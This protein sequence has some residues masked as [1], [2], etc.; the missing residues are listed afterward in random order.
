MRLSKILDV[1]FGFLVV[2]IGLAVL[3]LFA[4][5]YVLYEGNVTS[6]YIIL[7]VALNLILG[8]TG[9]LAFTNGVLFGVGAYAAAALTSRAGIPYLLALPS[10]AVVAMVVG[11]VIALPALRLSGLYLAMASVAFAQTAEWVFLH[12]DWATGGPSGVRMAMIRYPIIGQSETAHYYVS[13][14]VACIVVVL[15]RNLLRSRIGR[16][17][18]AIRESEVGA[19]SLA[20]DITRYKTLAYAASALL[21][22]LAG[23]LFAPLLGLV[24]PESYDLSQIVLQFAMV[25]VGGLGSVFG[26]IVGAIGLVWMQEALRAFKELQEIAFGGMILLTILFLPGGLMGFVR[27]RLPGWRE[28]FS[29]SVE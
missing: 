5:D 12:W 23:G 28:A 18:V 6:I 2:A 9:L 17:F 21:A 11:V 16:A 8:Y 15:V 25:V 1:R 10:S 26:S 19:E 4:N 22:G 7:A 24:V 20:I 14:A 27:A 3:P 13:F 29:R